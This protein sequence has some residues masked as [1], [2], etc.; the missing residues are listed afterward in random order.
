MCGGLHEGIV[1]TIDVLALPH[2]TN[3]RAE[4]PDLDTH[5]S[6]CIFTHS[7]DSFFG[8]ANIA[9]FDPITETDFDNVGRRFYA[10]L[11]AGV[12]CFIHE[13]KSAF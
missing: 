7:F 12:R 2:R 9:F 3:R 8:W 13:R 10:P 5:V 4:L 6:S 1:G 11:C